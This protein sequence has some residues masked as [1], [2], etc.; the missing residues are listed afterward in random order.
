[1][2]DTAH[3]EAPEHEQRPAKGSYVVDLRQDR[4]GQVMGHQGPYVQLRPL[5][6]GREWDV[7]P[8]DVRPA[9]DTERLK[10]KVQAAN[11]DSSDGRGR[12]G[13]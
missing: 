3:R 9:T 12:W 8:D 13:K 5:R 10:A 6:G 2:N 7:R 1:M 4:I 11:A